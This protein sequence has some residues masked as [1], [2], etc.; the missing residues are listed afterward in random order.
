MS[1]NHAGSRKASAGNPTPGEGLQQTKDSDGT[2]PKR[3]GI[4]EN[5]WS[6]FDDDGWGIYNVQP[7]QN[8]DKEK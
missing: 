5:V 4:E 6:R 8:A 3:P 7:P 2:A 1:K